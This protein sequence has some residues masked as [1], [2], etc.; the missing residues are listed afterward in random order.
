MIVNC[1]YPDYYDL[2]FKNFIFSIR[3]SI[4]FNIYV[5]DLYRIKVFN[6]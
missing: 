3:L 5:V 2:K 4:K 6:I 1:I